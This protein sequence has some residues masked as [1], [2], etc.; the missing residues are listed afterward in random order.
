MNLASVKIALIG[1][2]A[3]FDNKETIG[4]ADDTIINAVKLEFYRL[5]F[6]LTPE[7]EA[8]LR[9]Y[10]KETFETVLPLF[11]K[12]FTELKGV[13]VFHKPLFTNFP[14]IFP[15]G[16]RI[17][18]ATSTFNKNFTDFLNAI[19]EEFRSPVITDDSLKTL[20]CG[21]KVSVYLTDSS[22]CPL[23]ST[24]ASRVNVVTAATYNSYETPMSHT[25]LSSLMSIGVVDQ[26]G[27]ETLVGNI[28]CSNS[29]LSPVNC[30]VLQRFI[31]N[32]DILAIKKVLPEQIPFKEIVSYVTTFILKKGIGR[33]EV[34]TLMGQYFKTAK[35]VMRLAEDINKSEDDGKFILSNS[36][37]KL[38]VELLS[39]IK[40]PDE[41]MVKERDKWVALNMAVHFGTF[42]KK[43]PNMFASIDRVLNRPE[44][45]KT[46]EGKL[47]A[48][49]I[50][51]NIDT[52]LD[53]LKSR[54]GVFARNMDHIVRKF[55]ES[56]DAICDAFNEV[57]YMV[58][59]RV[60]ITLH[61]NF[62]SRLNGF[63]GKRMFV[64]KRGF[65]QPITTVRESIPDAT[66]EQVLSTIE[67]CLKK[68]LKSDVSTKKI[69]IDQ[70]LRDYKVPLKMRSTKNTLH[71][72]ERGSVID[73]SSHPN[74]DV[75]RMFIY[76]KENQDS[77][78][79]DLDL[80][81]MFLDDNF[82]VVGQCA[83][84]DLY[85]DDIEVRHSGDV[86]EAPEGASEFIDYNLNYN[87][88]AR[89]VVMYVNS[90]TNQSF[91]N[92]DAFCGVM[93]LNN[94]DINTLYQPENVTE[95][96]DLTNDA[97]A[98]LC[99]IY[100]IKLK[101]MIWADMNRHT[102]T[103]SNLNSESVDVVDTIKYLINESETALSM[104][105]LL[106]LYAEANDIEIVGDNEKETADAQF[107]NSMINN[108]D[109]FTKEWLT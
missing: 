62:K 26:Q 61:N 98:V 79:V 8:V 97:K 14:N 56:T 16:V 77:G 93:F 109:E 106:E 11:Y 46:F 30:Q 94:S 5:G 69:W 29:A 104:Q 7:A 65:T 60:L 99:Y 95:R 33:N 85:N 36:Q 103:G 87:S 32:S 4:F 57:G 43:Y 102:T 27:I 88:S 71:K 40:N 49:I 31:N 22:E 81:A 34:I 24:N 107:D 96:F 13:G 75:M 67:D 101:K 20:E 12:H 80:S 35:D 63:N 51:K 59:K 25:H 52:I 108:T 19:D 55:P 2:N 41:D 83:Y 48:S 86:V 3:I 84:Y 28:L 18:K 76:W 9:G 17:A 70:S 90:F 39:N 72:A 53:L 74:T 50:S 1:K 23:C 42:K 10:S 89:Y 45:I 44:T 54:P 91:D 37:R 68:S 6:Y 21:H 15:D 66:C 64:N 47:E 58:A 100:D 78:R 105:R 73:Y 38:I 82:N 92:F